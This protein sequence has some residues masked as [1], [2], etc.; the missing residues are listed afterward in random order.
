MKVP[1]T[2]QATDRKFRSV[3]GRSN[4]N[5]SGVFS[6]VIDTEWNCHTFRI[7][8]E[9]RVSLDWFSTPTFSLASKVSY[10]LLLF[11]IDANDRESV[12]RGDTGP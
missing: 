5:V 10:E 7:A 6:D 3:V 2:F 4:R 8:R 9:M 11:G 1:P 12:P